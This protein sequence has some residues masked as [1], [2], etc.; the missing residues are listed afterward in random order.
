MESYKHHYIDNGFLQY[1]H[2][3]DLIPWMLAY[4]CF[5]LIHVALAAICIFA[6]KELETIDEAISLASFALIIFLI[7][8]VAWVGL[9][10]LGFNQVAFMVSML[11]SMAACA[12]FF[13]HSITFLIVCLILRGFL[14]LIEYLFKGDM[15]LFLDMILKAGFYLF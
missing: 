5:I 6:S 3:S 12:V 11:L 7:S 14:Y 4:A 15:P 2:L 10:E 13:F 1:A 9:T 8:D